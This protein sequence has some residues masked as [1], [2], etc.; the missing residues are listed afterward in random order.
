MKDDEFF[1]CSEML[2]ACFVDVTAQVFDMSPRNKTIL[3]AARAIVTEYP[4][5]I[6]D[7]MQEMES[8]LSIK[9]TLGIAG[10]YMRAS[11]PDYMFALGKKYQR[12]KR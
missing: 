5:T 9:D 10:P 8:A 6:Q 1:C 11:H 12:G 2:L 4:I 3:P 7:I